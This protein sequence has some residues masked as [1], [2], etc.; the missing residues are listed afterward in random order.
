MTEQPNH[1]QAQS[2]AVW[3]F[4]KDNGRVA[5]ELARGLIRLASDIESLQLALKASPTN[6]SVESI[7]AL[8]QRLGDVKTWKNPD[9]AQALAELVRLHRFPLLNEAE[10]RAE[11][12]AE[13]KRTTG[14]TWGQHFDMQL[15]DTWLGGDAATFTSLRPAIIARLQWLQADRIN[16]WAYESARLALRNIYMQWLMFF[17]FIPLA[18]LG[19]IAFLAS[20]GNSSETQGWWLFDA[21]GLTSWKTFLCTMSMGV[22]GA[23]LT[24]AYTLRDQSLNLREMRAVGSMLG[25]Q[26]MLGAI[27]AMLICL[28]VKSG[29]L[30][31]DRL[32]GAEFDW[33]DFAVTGFLAGF[34]EA[35]FLGTVRRVLG[36]IEEA[37]P[38]KPVTKA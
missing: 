4:F 35:F 27:S 6:Q 29:V 37:A 38:G 26:S 32:F 24:T 23:L 8:L 22:I 16:A 9:A 10:L 3:S 34:S 18:V 14:V 25:I 21:Q 7:A 36:S 12:E 30:P 5:P 11:L 19:V 1:Q 2:T 31:V 17:L 33:Q 13:K 15:L 28:F 20:I